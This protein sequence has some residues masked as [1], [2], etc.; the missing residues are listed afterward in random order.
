MHKSLDF[1]LQ[2][3]YV[4]LVGWVFAEQIGLPLP[5]IPLLLAAGALAG[6]HRMNIFAALGC[7]IV[8]SVSADLIW[9]YL[10]KLRGIRVLQLICKISLEPDSCVRKTEGV[11]SKQGAKS[12]LVAKFV[13]GL[14]TVAPPMAGVF[15]MRLRRFVLFDTLGTIFWGG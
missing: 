14:S 6:S 4:L 12:L 1:V 7:T 11:F 9:F 3:G 15:H 5:S 8:G 13:P 10:G 2:H